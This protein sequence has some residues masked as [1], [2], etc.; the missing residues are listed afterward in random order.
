MHKPHRQIK[1]PKSLY[2]SFSCWII[3]L[4]QR[5]FYNHGF[6]VKRLEEDGID[7]LIVGAMKAGTSTLAEYCRIHPEIEMLPNE[8]RFFESKGN[9]NKGLH[10]YLSKFRFD[11]G[12][13]IRGEKSATY[14]CTPGAASRIAKH[15]PDVKLIWILR[16]PVKR[17]Y[18]HYWHTIKAGRER[19]PI[20]KCIYD[21]LNNKNTKPIF[22]YLDRSRYIEHVSDYLRFFNRNQM[23]FVLFEDLKRDPLQVVKKVYS[24]L[25]VDASIIPPKNMKTNITRIPLFIPLQW[26]LFQV[27]SKIIS[28]VGPNKLLNL[29]Y[30]KLKNLLK[31]RKPGYPPMK[32]YLAS[33]LSYYFAPYNQELENLIDI[34]TKNWQ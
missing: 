28:L 11:Y 19:R 1:I 25:G 7:F 31:K 23:L 5:Y 3:D 20:T 30:T 18:S 10:W 14:Y 27:Y 13:K 33:I 29:F 2:F 6:K 9:Y 4:R 16:D 12:E 17:L 22:R 24:F 8:T 15:F 21:N 26:G 32:E 34:D